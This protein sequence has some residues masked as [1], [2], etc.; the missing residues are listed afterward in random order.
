MNESIPIPRGREREG[1]GEGARE[2]LKRGG[3]KMEGESGKEREGE[4][5]RWRKKE[6]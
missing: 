2:K 3:K 6:I 5:K 4:R 1:G